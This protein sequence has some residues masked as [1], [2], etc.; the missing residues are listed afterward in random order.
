[1]FKYT[2]A[3]PCRWNLDLRIIIVI[4]EKHE[5]PTYGEQR[6]LKA[7]KKIFHLHNQNSIYLCNTNKKQHP[8]NCGTNIC[9]HELTIMCVQMYVSAEMAKTK[10]G[11]FSP[12]NRIHLGFNLQNCL[13]KFNTLHRH[14]IHSFIHLLTTIL[15]PTIWVW[16]QI[17]ISRM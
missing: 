4:L 16:F 8:L 17:T 9:T 7:K 15:T 11:N 12:G 5:I 14:Y 13:L 10:P 3:F 6:C 1:M 2:F